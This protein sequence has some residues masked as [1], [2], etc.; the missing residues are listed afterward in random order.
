VQGADRLDDPVAGLGDRGGPSGQYRIGVPDAGY[1]AE[2]LNS[3][4]EAFGGTN[5]G[6][7]GGVNSEPVAAH[8]FEH[9]IRLTIP[10]LGCLLL[11]KR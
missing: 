11:K 3:D 4:A 6:N 2:V 5:V 1:Y 10:P 7:N 8:G 9:S